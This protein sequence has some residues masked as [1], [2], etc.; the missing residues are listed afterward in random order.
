MR[1]RWLKKVERQWHAV[2]RYGWPHERY[3][4][5]I[6]HRVGDLYEV[7]SL[8]IP[9]D[10]AAYASRSHVETPDKWASDAIDEAVHEAAQVIGDIHSHPRTFK[11]W[12]GSLLDCVPS[13][14]DFAAGWIGACGITVASEQRNGRIKCRTRFYSPAERVTIL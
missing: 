3:A 10:V 14:G 12:K 8:Y 7:E 5:L 11:S 6:G 4:F 2:C 13:E 9:A 1:L